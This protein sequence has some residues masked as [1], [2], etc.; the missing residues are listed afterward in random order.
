M[1]PLM[2]ASLKNDFAKQAI[3]KIRRLLKAAFTH[4]RIIYWNEQ[5]YHFI[6]IG[7]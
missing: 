2:L 5:F 7:I 1:T 4:V 3:V 6:H